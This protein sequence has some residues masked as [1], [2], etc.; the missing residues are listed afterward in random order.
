[1]KLVY[2]LENHG[3]KFTAEYFPKQK[4]IQEALEEIIITLHYNDVSDKIYEFTII[5]KGIK[6]F[7]AVIDT[8][9]LEKQFKDEIKAYFK[10]IVEEIYK[11]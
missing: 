11:Q 1:M 2:E 6:R 9:N 3:A 7:L 5:R 10:E 4:E 8:E